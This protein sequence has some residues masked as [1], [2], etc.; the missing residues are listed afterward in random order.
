[1]LADYRTDKASLDQ[2]EQLAG[3]LQKSPLPQFKDTLGWV[4]YREGNY[5]AAIPL[6]QD[7]AAALP[8]VALI[9]YHLG[10]SYLAASQPD[11]ATEQFKSALDHAPD[12]DLA[13]KIRAAIA[14]KGT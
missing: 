6:L 1:L 7:A 2:A 4:D 13:A 11:K 10:M 9:H 12:P 5:N 14:K 8:N 3:G